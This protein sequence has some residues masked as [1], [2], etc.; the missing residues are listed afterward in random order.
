MA[1]M[2]K[3]AARDFEDLLQVCSARLCHTVLSSIPQCS[4]P[5][6]EGLFPQKHNKI[7]MDLLYDLS[8]W[9]ALAKLR[10]HTDSSLQRLS[11][12]T[13]TLGSSLQSF[14]KKTCRAFTASEL[15]REH[16][17]RVRREGQSSTGASTRKPRK[18]N[19]ST[20]KLHALGDYAPT[21]PRFGTSDGY[22]TQIV[23]K[24]LD[25][26]LYLNINITCRGN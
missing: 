22:S 11:E 23:S 18:F 5:V 14:S 19:L 7:V 15:P 3:L 25:F 9:H 8:Y 13:G 12:G 2:I 26:T 20:Y 21:I 16:D 10:L 1:G 17:A 6:F 4:M 24:C